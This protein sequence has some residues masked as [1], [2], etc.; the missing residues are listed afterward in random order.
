MPT[1]APFLLL[2][3]C[4]IA[5]AMLVGFFGGRLCMGG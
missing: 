2:M 1:D 3:A 4:T 5:M